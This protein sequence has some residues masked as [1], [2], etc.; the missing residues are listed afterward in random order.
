MSPPQEWEREHGQPVDRTPPSEA[1]AEEG[2]ANR[3]QQ[4][5]MAGPSA[6]AIKWLNGHHK[7]L[8]TQLYTSHFL[9]TWNSRLFEFGAV[10]FLAS[11]FPHTLLPMSIYALTRSASAILLAQIIGSWIDR[12]NRLSVVRASIIGQRV[13]VAA[14][15]GILWVMEGRAGLLRVSRVDG[16]FVVLCLLA[17]IEKLSA[18]ANLISIERDWV[19]VMTEGDEHWRRGKL[20][21]YYVMV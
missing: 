7:R 19:V 16:L 14:S 10:L 6:R 15:C 5:R 8:E 18:M 4:H 11:I 17:C 12:G 2:T 13:A 3:P 1:V 21:L 20:S 9:S